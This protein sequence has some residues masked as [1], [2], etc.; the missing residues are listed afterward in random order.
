MLGATSHR[1]YH[2][3][4]SKSERPGQYCR[5]GISAVAAAVEHQGECKNQAYAPSGSKRPAKGSQTTLV[6]DNR[7]RK[8]SIDRLFDDE[9]RR[10]FGTLIS[11][12][13]KNE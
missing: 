13:A 11:R 4:G 3:S 2:D 10:R 6:Y 8:D 5:I 9:I 7:V 12:A 1:N